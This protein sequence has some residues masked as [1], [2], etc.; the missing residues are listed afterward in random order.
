MKTATARD[1]RQ[2]TASLLDH[3]R[4]G[5]EVIITY[6]GRSVAALV[7]LVAAQRTGLNP[8]GFGMWRDRRDMRSVEKWLKTL[9][10]PRHRG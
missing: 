1:L 8:V 7:P 10:A 3:V 5:R 2:K 6:R 9:R 4:K